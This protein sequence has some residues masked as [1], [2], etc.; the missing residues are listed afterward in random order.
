MLT[1]ASLPIAD[2]WGAQ[3]SLPELSKRSYLDLMN[4]PTDVRYSG[5]E[6]QQVRKELSKERELEKQRLQKEEKAL[7][8]RIEALRD[9]LAALNKE[10]SEDTPRMKE[11]RNT[12]HCEILRLQ[13]ERGDKKLEREKGMPVA[14][15]NRFAKLKLV[16]QWPPKRRAIMTLVQEGKARQRP[17]GDVEDI[18]V[19]KVS[20]DQEKDI[21][22][23]EE[24][25]R[26]L[27]LYSMMPPEVED[28]KVTTYLQ[29]M[30]ERIRRNSDVTVPVKLRLLRSEEI[31]AFALPGGFLFVNTGLVAK[32][33]NDS[34]LAGVIAHELAHVSGRHGAKLMKRATIASILY[35]VAQVAAVI[36]SGGI[37]TI[38]TYYAL[39][40]GFFGLGMLLELSLLGVSREFEAE[41]DQLGAQYAWKAGYDPRG[42]I[43]FFD[44]MASEK[45]YVT[46]ASFFRTHPPF[47]ERILATF[48][49]IEYLPKGGDLAIESNEF[50]AFQARV[51]ETVKKAAPDGKRPTLRKGEPECDELPKPQ[52]GAALSC[53]LM[54]CV[55][56][57]SHALQ[58]I[59]VP[60]RSS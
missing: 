7:E 36:A 11:R 32:A 51:T 47:F 48:S 5:S 46:S 6:Y 24:A 29:E 8:A 33:E 40:Y 1:A 16:E 52:S 21:K 54:P 56:L 58:T 9:D 39:Q 50:R 20:S 19:R 35:Q 26:D 60:L 22:L 23:G 43:T 53:N 27:K 41:A 28:E 55:R 59:S 25:I 31:N 13:K 30:A 45:G 14:F 18:G 42:F 2:A 10:A 12:L 17:Y 4:L 34:E 38:G 3:S 57:N 37:S 49:E 15:D 44:K